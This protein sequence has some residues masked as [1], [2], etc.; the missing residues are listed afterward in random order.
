VACHSVSSRRLRGGW[1]GCDRWGGSRGGP[2]VQASRPSSRATVS[3]GGG[4]GTGRAGSGSRDTFP[5]PGPLRTGRAS[6][7]ASGSSRPLGRYAGS[8]AVSGAGA[9]LGTGADQVPQLATGGVAAL[10]MPVVT[11]APGDLFKLAGRN[12]QACEKLLKIHRPVYWTREKLLTA[13]GPVPGGCLVPGARRRIRLFRC[14]RMTAV[15]ASVGDRLT[16]LVHHG[17]AP[18]RSGVERGSSDD[19]AGNGTPS[20]ALAGRSAAGWD[21]GT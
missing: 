10:G 1:C 18:S 3:R 19:G 9:G 4:H 16:L 15:R 7:P 8:S 20:A 21:G 11:G 6:F 17:E 14:P 5:C 12:S 13:G 2:R